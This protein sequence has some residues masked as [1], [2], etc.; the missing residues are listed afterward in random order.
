MQIFVKTLTGKTITLDVEPSD[1][2]ENVKTK[3]QD[4]E[5]IP[6]DQQ[7]LIFAGKQLEDGRTLSD[8][9]IQKESTLHLVLRLRGGVKCVVRLHSGK[10]FVSF[11]MEKDLIK[12]KHVRQAIRENFI[13]ENAK[14][15]F[16]ALTYE[17]DEGDV[18]NLNLGVAVEFEEALRVMFK[19]GDEAQPALDFT[20]ATVLPKKNKSHEAKAA[21]IVPV[22]KAPAKEDC[23]TQKTPSKS[24]ILPIELVSNILSF[25][26]R[27]TP[28]KA[29]PSKPKAVATPPVVAPG[30]INDKAK[31]AFAKM[32]SVFQDLTSDVEGQMQ[33]L[34]QELD[35]EKKNSKKLAAFSE[36][37]KQEAASS[38]Q[39]VTSLEKAVSC[40]QKDISKLFADV[41]KQQSIVKQQKDIIDQQSNVVL[42]MQ[43][44]NESLSA[45]YEVVIKREK[46]QR[47][48]LADLRSEL[49]AK[50]REL[51]DNIA[52]Q[53]EELA[54]KAIVIDDLQKETAGL[55]DEN[56]VL[57]AQLEAVYGKIAGLLPDTAKQTKQNKLKQTL[58]KVKEG[59][60]EVAGKVEAVCVAGAGELKEAVNRTNNY[61]RA[62]T[63]DE[64]SAFIQAMDELTLTAEEKKN[65][66]TLSSMGFDVPVEQFKELLVKHKNLDRI[67]ESLL[68]Q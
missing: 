61:A 59:V 8:Y 32:Q 6:P 43:C 31:A 21:P 18:I 60:V 16:P 26:R 30:S 40:A 45:D 52:A 38:K 12:S 51:V 53:R 20:L 13:L 50:N 29:K 4:K 3:I 42:E 35:Q 36:T 17:D 47:G 11:E 65:Y 63:S 58:T 67:V 54:T 23:V 19:K 2:I 64:A 33:Q 57:K 27:S 49:T 14:G 56:A 48:K 39:L 41:A 22:P 1:S 37:L 62:D 10:S 46:E 28:P 44:R 7:R 68:S 66:G 15:E 9:N 5:G 24:Q 34:T 25:A 55:R